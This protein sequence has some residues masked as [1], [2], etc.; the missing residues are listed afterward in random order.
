M[1]GATSTITPPFI[2]WAQGCYS[3]GFGSPMAETI[4]CPLWRKEWSRDGVRYWARP[5][6]CGRC[7]ARVLVSRA[8]QRVIDAVGQVLVL[9][10]HCALIQTTP[11]ATD[12][13][14]PPDGRGHCSTCDIFEEQL[15]DTRQEMERAK[16]SERPEVVEA[17]RRKWWHLVHG[18][19]SHRQKQHRP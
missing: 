9:C 15:S 19:G 17:A 7:G 3:E 4:V 11:E 10:D 14:W 5:V 13:F 18:L 16:N 1:L 12:S 6:P 8:V 2:L